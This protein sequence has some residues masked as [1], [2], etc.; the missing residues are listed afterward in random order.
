MEF[1]AVQ[2]A[3]LTASIQ[4]LQAEGARHQAEIEQ[5]ARELAASEEMRLSFARLNAREARATYV[6]RSEQASRGPKG[7]VAAQNAT[8]E[9]INV[10]IRACH[11]IA[12]GSS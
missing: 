10:L 12:G 9:N 11:A 8:G 6:R 7:A 4:P 5:R 2:Q 1:I 3:A